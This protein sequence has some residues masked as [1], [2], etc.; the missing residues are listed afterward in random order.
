[1]RQVDLRF[2]LRQSQTQGARYD[3]RL[4]SNDRVLRG[5]VAARDRRALGARAIGGFSSDIGDWSGVGVMI[6]Y[7]L[8]FYAGFTPRCWGFGIEFNWGGIVCPASFD[9]L[10]GPWTFSVIDRGGEIET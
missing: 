5:D 10:V 4:E 9:V 6:S 7:T 1:M 3:G 2:S 8:E